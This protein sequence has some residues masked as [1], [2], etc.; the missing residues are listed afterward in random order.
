MDFQDLGGADVWI[1]AFAG[2]TDWWGQTTLIGTLSAI[3]ELIYELIY[4]D[5]QDGQDFV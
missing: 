5:V 3:P 1:P 4:R 2:M